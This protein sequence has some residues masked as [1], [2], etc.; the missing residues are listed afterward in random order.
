MGIGLN[1]VIKISCALSR[2]LHVF[3]AIDMDGYL[4][5]GNSMNYAMDA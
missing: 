4:E 2:G 1:H 5:N 3:L